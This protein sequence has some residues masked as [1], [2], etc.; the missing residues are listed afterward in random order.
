MGGCACPTVNGNSQ[1][2]FPVA[3]DQKTGNKYDTIQAAIDAAADAR[4]DF[5]PQAGTAAGILVL[6][7]GA[8]AVD[9][10]YK[11]DWVVDMDTTPGNGLVGRKAR[12]KSYVGATRTATLDEP[13][14][15]TGESTV[16]IVDP[17]VVEV[18]QDGETLE[19]LNIDKNL[20]LELN[21]HSVNKIDVTFQPF[22]WIR[23]GNAFVQNGMTF[24]AQGVLWAD[25]ID[26]RARD[27]T[28]Y[29]YIMT[30]DSDLGRTIFQNCHFAGV[31]AGRRGYGGW[32]IDD[33]KNEGIAE[34]DQNCPWRPFEAITGIA[35]VVKSADL[36][37]F[38]QYS[39]CV[40]YAEGTGSLTG[41]T[42]FVNYKLDIMLPSIVGSS[43][44]ET[45][46]QPLQF[47][48]FWGNGAATLTI[49]TVA[50]SV[51]M[52]KVDNAN[53]VSSTTLISNPGSGAC[54]LVNFTGTFNVNVSN[55]ASND[56]T[57]LGDGSSVQQIL[58]MGSV[59]CTG[60]ITFAGFPTYNL[61][62]NEFFAQVF[63]KSAFTGTITDSASFNVWNAF[64][65]ARLRNFGTQTAGAPVV[66]LSGTATCTKLVQF[67]IFSI[68]GSVSVGTYTISGGCTALVEGQL[69]MIN[70]GAAVS[71]GTWTVSGALEWSIMRANSSA[72]KLATA[73]ATG[74]TL[75]VSSA[76][77]RL[78]GFGAN[79]ITL[80]EAT[81][82]GMTVNVTATSITVRG[83]KFLAATTLVN[84]TAS[85]AVATCTGTV[86]FEECQ[87]AAAITIFNA[88]SGSGTAQAPATLTFDNCFFQS[89]FTDRSGAG[90]L[91]LA[92]ANWQFNTC[93]FTG[94]FTATGTSFTTLYWFTCTFK[95][96]PIPITVSGTRPTNYTAFKCQGLSDM[97]LTTNTLEVVDEYFP[98]LTSV[99][100]TRGDLITMGIGIGKWETSTANTDIIEGIA[101][102]TV[103]AVGQCIGVVRGRVFVKVDPTVVAK[104]Y[105]IQDPAIP[106]EAI[107]GAPTPGK[108][109]IRAFENAGATVTHLAYSS[110]GYF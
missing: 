38:G 109:S 82:A 91:T 75:T 18:Y 1:S 55:N 11:N 66:T 74:G 29:A 67:N 96:S 8:S 84:S 63:L 2:D 61:S 107:A 104:D 101:L 69:G 16:A 35:V 19:D 71:G 100:V 33:C 30:N 52:C 23:G 40:N 36:T 72:L 106:S 4:A 41:P 24:T 62:N 27:T 103:G 95:A 54:N 50:G 89:T 42:A 108:G 51:S 59:T 73:A 10:A 65:V 45:V 22:C 88:T 31:V 105:C 34:T 14:N 15:F 97:W 77:I 49:A 102:T 79:S 90:T 20:I 99:G 70:L 60:S 46:K 98:L 32:D 86:Q 83:M 68:F 58:V 26:V 44:V 87:W 43:A 39:G 21:G 64:T 80:A 28:V 25:N 53:L 5:V 12:I 47:Y 17:A 13:W 7:A 56:F 92:T 78:A 76:T 9:D 57:T 93:T 110:V 3:I 6:P 48:I 85:T 94:L 81:G 37:V